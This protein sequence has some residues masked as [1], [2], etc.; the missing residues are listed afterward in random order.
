MQKTISILLILTFLPY[1]L[2]FALAPSY[3]SRPFGK[4]DPRSAK[5]AEILAT[6][7][8][9]L[10][11]KMERRLYELQKKTAPQDYLP[12]GLRL[13]ASGG[14][15]GGNVA[16]PFTL[17][18]AKEAINV[19][20]VVKSR[21]AAAPRGSK[22]GGAPG[23]AKAGVSPEEALKAMADEYLD[24]FRQYMLTLHPVTRN[25]LIKK[26]TAMIRQALKCAN[27]DPR[28]ALTLLQNSL[29]E[30]EM[31][32]KLREVS[33]MQ[34][35]RKEVEASI[36]EM[37]AQ[38][39]AA[40][41]Q[42]AVTILGEDG[43]AITGQNR[44]AQAGRDARGGGTPEAATGSNIVLL[45]Y[46]SKPTLDAYFDARSGGDGETLKKAR[47]K[48][49]KQAVAATS[50]L[51]PTGRQALSLVLNLM[52]QRGWD[53]NQDRRE[54]EAL[55]SRIDYWTNKFSPKSQQA[56]KIVPANRRELIKAAKDSGFPDNIRQD[57][58]RKQR[59][60]QLLQVRQL[61]DGEV[62]LI[63][64]TGYP[65]MENMASGSFT[66]ICYTLLHSDGKYH[67]L[68]V[69]Y[70][71]TSK[72]LE[73]S[74]DL[75]DVV[76]G[77]K[78]RD[79]IIR[80]RLLAGTEEP[81]LWKALGSAADI[82]DMAV[83]QN[84]QLGE[85]PSPEIVRGSKAGI[86]ALP[87]APVVSPAGRF[88]DGY[89]TWGEVPGINVFT[90]YPREGERVY[91]MFLSDAERNDPTLPSHGRADFSNGQ[92]AAYVMQKDIVHSAQRVPMPE[93]C[94]KVIAFLKN[95]TTGS[96]DLYARRTVEHEYVIG[97]TKIG[98]I[99]AIFAEKGKITVTF[100]DRQ[101]EFSDTA[102]AAQVREANSGIAERNI[103]V[104]WRSYHEARAAEFRSGLIRTLTE[105]PDKEFVL[106]VDTDIG[107][108]HKAQIMPIWNAFDDIR[109]LAYKDGK[110]LFPNLSIIRGA[111]LTL[112]SKIARARNE[113][114]V[115][116]GSIF[117]VAKK[118]NV[119]NRAFEP[120]TGA[121]IAAIDDS[122]A[123]EGVYMPVFEAATI[124]M[125]AALNVDSAAIKTFCDSITDK[126][127]DP[128]AIDEFKRGRILYLMPRAARFDTEKALRDVYELARITYTAA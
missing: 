44:Q 33:L 117:V 85:S 105:H 24:R 20:N 19:I 70:H 50:K 77:I 86:A 10:A 51:D 27:D 91:V 73:A 41:D 83:R 106:A 110:P 30:C 122:A 115:D 67:M 99:A 78:Y 118:A 16:G 107:G 48:A 76:E 13:A 15:N 35:E 43:K 29:S 12:A 34:T 40:G 112:A 96:K 45:Q 42:T 31:W 98:E 57:F 126:P 56:K 103:A 81:L 22:A 116:L 36:R 39:E 25:I 38:N 66:T 1:N 63:Y 102:A 92:F 127:I 5:Q 46:P 95:A 89:K 6:A 71:N 47:D 65:V 60:I 11:V 7:K 14:S 100:G 68:P 123:G 58:E 93:V 124:T 55:S 32:E 97:S 28:D 94:N 128:K 69:S 59:G 119:D 113:K 74:I 80:S 79:L 125:M 37:A 62:V 120:L 8:K 23:S 18:E 64:S 49:A 111:G 88:A 75:D 53:V 109:K 54:F 104:D 108:A 2:A 26:R 72:G 52:E 61:R 9:A 21:T 84:V 87:A 3:V 4:E 17:K 101:E 121:W 90:F 114:S 82:V